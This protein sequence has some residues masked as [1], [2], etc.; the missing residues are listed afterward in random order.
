MR[1]IA[2]ATMVFLLG[3]FF[4]VS[5]RLRVRFG[6]LELA[7][8]AADCLLHDLFQL[9]SPARRWEQRK[10]GRFWLSLDLHCADGVVYL[11]YAGIWRYFLVFRRNNARGRDLLSRLTTSWAGTWR[12]SRN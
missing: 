5:T 4:A 11:D 2:L 10:A 7:E 3:T 6:L 1:S 12:S 8:R 9:E